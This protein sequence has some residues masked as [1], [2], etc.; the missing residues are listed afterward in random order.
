MTRRPRTPATVLRQLGR[1][2]RVVVALMS[3]GAVATLVM[4]A[5]AS[6]PDPTWFS[7]LYD[8]ADH[9]D[10]VLLA[11]STAGTLDGAA[12]LVARPGL[13]VVERSFYGPP[14]VVTVVLTADATRGPPALRSPLG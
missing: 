2:G 12:P 11:T 10:A 13:S 7:G 6:P 4:L 8:D 14:G 3:L 1:L 9:D 5:H